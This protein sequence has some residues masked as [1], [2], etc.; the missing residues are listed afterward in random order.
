M[1]K[2]TPAKVVAEAE[3]SSTCTTAAQLT[4]QASTHKP[5]KESERR[6]REVKR[7]KEKV[8]I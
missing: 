3:S 6:V 8:E 7:K 1:N 5:G 2:N 4:T